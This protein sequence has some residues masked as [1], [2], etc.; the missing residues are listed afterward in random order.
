KL[1]PV[2]YFLSILK[3]KICNSFLMNLTNVGENR[4]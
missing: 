3:P 1:S 4:L 2:L